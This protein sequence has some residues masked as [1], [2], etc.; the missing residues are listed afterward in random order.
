MLVK[1]KNKNH[2]AL[3]DLY[4]KMKKKYYNKMSNLYFYIYKYIYIYVSYILT[5]ML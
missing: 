2:C 3:F 5:N 4:L 1:L